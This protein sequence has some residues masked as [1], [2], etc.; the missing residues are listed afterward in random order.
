MA[1]NVEIEKLITLT[2]ASKLLPQVDGKRI[3]VSTLWRWC[4]RGRHG[5]TLD[6]LR[7]GSK[8]VTTQEAMQRFFIALTQLDENHPQAFIS[9]SV[10]RKNKPRSQAQRQREMDEANAILVRAGIIQPARQEAAGV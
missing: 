2:E 6:Y 10:R 4:R 8:I 5:I 3:H 9:T 1:I 7:V